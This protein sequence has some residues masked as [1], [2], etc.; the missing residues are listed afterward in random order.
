[1]GDG[2]TNKGQATRN[3]DVKKGKEEDYKNDSN[4]EESGWEETKKDCES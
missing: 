1:M 4:A 2:R 3:N